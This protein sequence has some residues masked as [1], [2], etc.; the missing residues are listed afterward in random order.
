MEVGRVGDLRTRDGSNV[1]LPLVGDRP[2]RWP[3]KKTF[4]KKKRLKANQPPVG[5][6]S[7]VSAGA[8]RKGLTRGGLLM[9]VARH[10][11]RD[12][13]KSPERRFGT[14]VMVRQK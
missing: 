11:A 5:R 13:Y 9:E 6:K 2:Y 10:S 4:S 12:G 1:R 14:V 8:T 3:G 7:A